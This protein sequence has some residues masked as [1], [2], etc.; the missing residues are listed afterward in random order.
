MRSLG[1]ACSLIAAL[2]LVSCGKAFEGPTPS[3]AA[4]PAVEPTAVC[5]EQL[6]TWVTVRGSGMSPLPTDL[7][8]DDPELVLPFLEL[9]RALDL[10]GNAVTETSL[11]IPDSLDLEGLDRVRWVSQE[12]MRFEVYPELELPTGLHTIRVT[13]GNG[14]A[15]E[16]PQALLALPRPQVTAVA[17]DLLCADAD[18][19]LTLTGSFFLRNGTALPRVV[20]AAVASDPIELAVTEMG[21]CRLLPGESGTEA[22]TEITVAVPR[23][24]LP[25]GD[26][27]LGYGLVVTNPDPAGCHSSDAIRVTMVPAPALTAVAPALV[28]TAQ[29]DTV[30]TITGSGFLTVDGAAP[31]LAVGASSYET[32]ASDCEPVTG[33]SEAVQRCATLSATIPEDDLAPGAYDVVVTNPAPA[34]CVS[35]NTLSLVVV[36]PPSVTAVVP[37]L[38]CVAQSDVSVSIE[39]SGFLTID[40]GAG[41]I[42]L[43]TVRIGD[44]DLVPTPSGCTAVAGT[45]GLVETCTELTVTVTQGLLAAGTWSVVVTNPATAACHSEE[46]ASLTVVAPP[47]ITDVTP[48]IVCSAASKEVTLTGTGFLTV[49]GALPTVTLDGTPLSITAS[50]CSPLVGPTEV[51]QT[52]TTLTATIPPRSTAALATLTVTNPTPAGCTSA[53]ASIFVTPPPALTAA[54][55]ADVCSTATSTPLSLTGTNLLVIGGVQPA[56]TVGG[57]GYAA[58]ATGC[59]AVTGLKETLQVCT[60]LAATLPAIASGSLAVVATNPAP[61]D[62]ASSGALVLP[63]VPPPTVTGVSPNKICVGGGTLNVT[64]TGFRAGAEV[65]LEGGIAV[66]TVTVL[67]S[68]QLLVTFGSTGVLPGG[69][70][71]LTVTNANG[72]AATLPD[73]VTVT[74]GPTLFFADPPVVYNGITTTITLYGSGFAGTALGLG[75]RRAGT[76]DAPTALT[77]SYDPAKANRV[78]AVVPAGTLAGDYDVILDDESSCDAVLASGLTIVDTITLEVTSITPPFGGTA[79]PT[80]VTVTANPAVGGGF[81]AVPRLYLSA[82]STGNASPL[83]SVAFL[84]AGRVTAIVPR[85]LAVGT[86]DL[87]AVNPDGG[88]GVLLDSFTISTDAPPVITSISPGSIP[89]QSGQLVKVYGANFQDTTALLRCLD[90][91]TNT[92]VER[93]PPVTPVNAGEVDLTVDASGFSKGA[94][95]VVRIVD[96]VNLTY[97]EFSSLVITNLSQNLSNWT[98]GP[99]MAVKRRALVSVGNQATPAARFVYAIGGDE[100]TTATPLGS[101]EVAPVDIFG[102]PG[103]FFT[104]REALGTARSFAGAAALGRCQYVVGGISDTDILAT[105]ER[106]CVLDPADRPEITDLDLL[107][108]ESAGLGGGL[109]YYQVAALL[110]SSHPLNPGGETLPSEPFPVLL[111]ALAEHTI[112]V[113]VHWAAIAGA[114]G[115]RVYRSATANAPL[116]EVQLLAEVGTVTSY[117]DTGA[118]VGTGRPHQLGSTGA[119]KTLAATLGTARQGPGVAI[120]ADPGDTTGTLHNL[121]VLGGRTGPNAAATSCERLPV[122]INGDGSHTVGT[123]T[124]CGQAL[125]TNQGRW[126]LALFEVGNEDASFVT[127]PTRFLYAGPGAAAN[128]NNVVDAMDAFEVL[129]GGALG[130]RQPVTTMNTPHGGYGYAAANNFLYVF[131]GT[132]LQPNDTAYSVK[133]CA[134]A[135]ATC[136]AGPPELE[137]WNNLMGHLVE[138]RYLTGSA[139]QSAYIYLLGG[140]TDTEAA[141]SSTEYAIW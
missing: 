2:S 98:A 36:P 20:A 97:G 38:A 19:Q 116:G 127:A 122:T 95:C 45:G 58:T 115:Y 53:A 80:A 114:T 42:S 105:I 23:G 70:Y 86:Y 22:C 103:A 47:A 30:L 27:W 93:T 77:T 102:Q 18:G 129:S 109:W 131:G 63:V 15:G 6:S 106:A 107:V 99:T 7:L 57:T 54:D 65:N 130:L 121:Y 66:D 81:Q 34:D 62:C 120:A 89:N 5:V 75:I 96:P 1:L 26:T 17:P 85:G 55:P 67:S 135:T 84:D 72:C 87:I 124:D 132:A 73:A 138:A 134:A 123:F 52:C 8:R 49:G 100:G 69:P 91:N 92:V 88:V 21:Q 137:N 40:D 61:A 25:A 113:T 112:E 59:Q 83:G 128:G 3:A 32:V 39:G 28:C 117:T 82:Q 76:A 136:T 119:W 33:P 44:Q 46:A 41:T 104:Q 24:T 10:D 78:K 141:T 140:Q 43:P 9:V 37:D 11:R 118:A 14:H 12:E 16:W 56:L 101:V 29:G 51:V 125:A 35:S 133:L 48:D 68:T 13:N 4:P 111:P 74:A 110:P 79:E 108:V 94:V 60:G 64:G 50:G 90:F 139:L 31:T 71:D 126:Q